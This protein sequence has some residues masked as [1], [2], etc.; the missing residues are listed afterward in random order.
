MSNRFKPRP[1]FAQVHFLKSHDAALPN[2]D[3]SGRNKIQT[4]GGAVRTRISSQAI[5]RRL[6]MADDIYA[7]RNIAGAPA[8]YR[9]RETINLL[10]MAPLYDEEIAG[11]EV[12]DAIGSVL[13]TNIYSL[14]ADEREHRQSMLLGHGEVMYLAAHARTIAESFPEDTDAEAAADATK[15]LFD[16]K[17]SDNFKAFR[18]NTVLAAGLEAALY[19]RMVTSDTRANIDG[20]ISMAHAFTIHEAEHDDEFFTTQDDLHY[21]NGGPGAAMLEHS[22]IT[23]G[24]YYGYAVADIKKLVANTE[25][26]DPAK[27]LEGERAMAA[28]IMHNF[29]QLIATVSTVAKL[30]STAA[31]SHASFIMVELGETQPRTLAGAYRVPAQPTLEDGL[32]RLATHAEG[33][34]TFIGRPVQRRHGAIIQAPMPNS[35]QMTSASDLA[36]WVHD[37]ILKGEVE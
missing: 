4:L 2:R 34:D 23:S 11:N 7:L 17:E 32:A 22:E 19:G 1:S 29:I 20:A 25:G 35:T 21:M 12:L 14:G 8:S 26:L 37:A 24:L 28:Q 6:R 18:Y 31:Y 33:F 36:M 15:A 13:N 3:R 16:E 5:K 30:G 27:W 10:V 9:S